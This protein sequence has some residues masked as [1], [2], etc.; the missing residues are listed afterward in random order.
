MYTNNVLDYGLPKQRMGSQIKDRGF[1]SRL[2]TREFP[3]FMSEITYE[4]KIISE[5]K[6]REVQPVKAFQ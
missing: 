6:R 1:K 3:Q 5:D 4:N 2:I